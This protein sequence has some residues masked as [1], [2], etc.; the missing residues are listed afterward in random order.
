M[1]GPG[2]GAR[3]RLAILHYAG[4]PLVGG[5][6]STIA[7]HARL[8]AKSGYPVKVV[9]GKGEFFHQGVTVHIV[10]E[11][12]SSHPDVLQVKGDLDVGKVA[13]RFHDLRRKLTARLDELLSDADVCIAHN[14]L[15][16]HKNLPLTAALHGLLGEGRIRG[17]ISWSHDFAWTSPNYRE[18]V[19]AGYPWDLLR[20][21]WPGVTYVTVSESRRVELAGMLGIPTNAIR[22]VRPGVDP[23]EFLGLQSATRLLA[24]RCRLWSAHPLLLLPARITRRKNIEMAV[25]IVGCLKRQF[26]QVRLLVSGPPGP[27]NPSNVAYLE[28]LRALREERGVQEEVVFLHEEAGEDGRRLEVDDAVMADLYRVADGLLFTSKQEGFGIPILEAGLSR[29]PLFCTDIPPFRETAEGVAHFFSP[30]D[31]PQ[32]VA[33]LIGRTLEADPAFLMRRRVLEGYTWDE[34]FRS[35]IEPLVLEVTTEGEGNEGD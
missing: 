19:H 22:A 33:E 29:M 15:T 13:T 31:E 27:H 20:R 23:G 32:R 34:V 26:P 21:P 2:E 16:L 7:H 9:V 30:E 6:E 5:V 18:E 1:K 12:D 35:R 28:G 24:Q 25:E 11:M 17:F 3:P 4:P 8:L 14:L 10:P